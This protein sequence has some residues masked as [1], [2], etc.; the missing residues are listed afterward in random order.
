MTRLTSPF[1]LAGVPVLSAPVGKIDNLPVGLQLVA[2]LGRESLLRSAAPS[3]PRSSAGQRGSGAPKTEVNDMTRSKRRAV[4]VLA[5]E[6]E[7]G[8]PA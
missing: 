1:N 2:G 6:R 3:L 4:A 5:A 7:G 8:G